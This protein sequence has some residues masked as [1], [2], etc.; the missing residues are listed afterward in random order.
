[1]W[2]FPEGHAVRAAEDSAKVA[3][4]RRIFFSIVFLLAGNAFLP[5][6][7]D[8]PKSVFNDFKKYFFGY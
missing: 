6:F 7:I 5:G 3:H 2:P 4:E 8:Y 1:M